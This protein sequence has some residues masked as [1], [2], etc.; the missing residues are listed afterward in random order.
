M[1]AARSALPGPLAGFVGVKGVEKGGEGKA[2]GKGRKGKGQEGRGGSGGKKRK[3]K[4]R[5]REG[6][7]IF[8][9]IIRRHYASDKRRSA[10]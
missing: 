5:G 10:Y 1:R 4:K 7:Q 2:R 3:G 9:E 6:P 8:R